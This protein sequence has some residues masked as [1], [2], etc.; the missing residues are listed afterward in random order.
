MQFNQNNRAAEFLRYANTI[1]NPQSLLNNPAFNSLKQKY[2]ASNPQQ[3]AI[4]QAQKLGITPTQLN[5][6]ARQLGITQ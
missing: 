5:Q 3:L 6:I 1:S 4:Q 2:N